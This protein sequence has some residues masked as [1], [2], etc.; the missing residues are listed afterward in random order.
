MADV[1]VCCGDRALFEGLGRTGKQ[2]DVLV[3]RK[4][5]AAVR[6]DDGLAVLC[7]AN[8]L[9]PVKRRPPPMF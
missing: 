5:F 3:V 2:C 7:L 9:H 1:A 8:D 4:V 6:F